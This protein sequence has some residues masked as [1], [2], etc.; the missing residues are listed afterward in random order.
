MESFFVKRIKSF[1]I[2]IE[3]LKSEAWKNLGTFVLA[4]QIKFLKQT[5]QIGFK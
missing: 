2:R 3:P 5:K 4:P 1:P